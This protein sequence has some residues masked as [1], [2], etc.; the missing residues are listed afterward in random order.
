[1][2]HSVNFLEQLEPESQQRQHQARRAASVAIGVAAVFVIALTAWAAIV[3][4]RVIAAAFDGRD[5]L[6]AAKEAAEEL[7]FERAGEQLA[8]AKTYFSQAQS[9][10]KDLRPV[11]LLPWIGTQLSAAEDLAT[12]GVDLIDVLEEIVDLGSELLRLS[13]LTEDMVEDIREGFDVSLSYDELSPETKRAVLQRL[14]GAGP[15]FAAMVA[16]IDLAVARL[17]ALPQNELVSPIADALGPL[18]AQ[19]GSARDSLDTLSIAAVILPEFGGLGKP[20]NILLLF[21]NNTELRPSAGFIGTYGIMVV[22]DGEI[23]ELATRDVYHL[24]Q[25]ADPY[26]FAEPPVPLKR[27]NATNEW[28]FRDSN[29]SPDFA[30]ASQDALGLYTKEV[31]AL[32]ADAR[33]ALQPLP[34]SID[35]VVALTPTF[36]SDILRITGPVTVG[37]QTFTAENIADT[38]EYQVEFGFAESG[39]PATQRKEILAD[40]VNETKAKLFDLP[41]MD[42][43][44]VIEAMSRNVDAK[45]LVLYSADQETQEVLT[46]AG[47]AGRATSETADTL[48]VVDANLASLKTDPEVLR[49]IDYA[50]DRSADGYVGR[51]T[52]TYTHQGAFDWKTTRYRTYTRVYVPAGSTLLSSSG[53]L[54]D[55]KL[56]N[57]S[58]AAGEVDVGSELGFTVFGAF[59]SIEPGETRELAFEY[60]LPASVTEAIENGRYDLTVLKQIGAAEHGLTLDLDFDKK[61]ATAAPAELEHFWGDDVY[62]GA[63]GLESDVVVDVEL[64]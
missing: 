18:R 3:S 16:K 14:S 47:W 50:I 30:V 5:A 54:R 20:S 59:T 58:G 2:Q 51:V 56:K 42:W 4:G 15:D 26:S 39:L 24:D 55:D 9:G 40:L 13:G 34:V 57:P 45:Q 6:L 46:Q 22:S 1:M 41:L 63:F 38:L 32:P 43:E 49:T 25:A 27:Y 35:A 48:L 19:L 29:W 17:D 44:R 8:K 36:A 23:V 60:L 28:F 37:G 61:V 52:I 33:E 12:V 11:T 64:E 53:A 10:L 62:S 7:D 21:T 31:L